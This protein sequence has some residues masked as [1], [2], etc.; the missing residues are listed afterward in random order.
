MLNM[1]Y[2]GIPTYDTDAGTNY[3][4]RIG[5]GLNELFKDADEANQD[6]LPE[7]VKFANG[8][9][10]GDNPL[11]L[12]EL[13]R[14]FQDID[15]YVWTRV[16]GIRLTLNDYAETLG[17]G[18]VTVS[19]E[20][21]NDQGGGIVLPDSDKVAPVLG[22][23]L[24]PIEEREQI[25]AIFDVRREVANLMNGD[26]RVHARSYSYGEQVSDFTV[27]EPVE[28]GSRARS[29]LV[30]EG[31]S[32]GISVP[33]LVPDRIDKAMLRTQAVKTQRSGRE[34]QIYTGRYLTAKSALRIMRE[35]I[36]W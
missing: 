8:R 32:V 30:T 14:F 33:L 36:L 28:I 21:I 5:E 7:G 9:L 1:G 23:V 18:L 34:S 31:S 22:S 12:F 29:L 24:P 2:S 27:D 13:Q 35:G 17:I 11:N 3:M 10:D 20:P 15:P 4:H 19:V 6:L 16:I 26:G 25:L